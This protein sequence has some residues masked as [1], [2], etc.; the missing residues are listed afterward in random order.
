MV[1]Q[2][3]PHNLCQEVEFCNE[4]D[5]A[6]SSLFECIQLGHGHLFLCRVLKEFHDDCHKFQAH[7]VVEV[8]RQ[9]ITNPDDYFNGCPLVHV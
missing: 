8:M 9:I 4:F 6:P 3:I 7:F 5:R 2:F 1:R